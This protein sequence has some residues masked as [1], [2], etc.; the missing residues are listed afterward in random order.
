MKRKKYYTKGKFELQI[1]YKANPIEV[2]RSIR[3]EKTKKKKFGLNLLIMV[4]KE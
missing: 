3:P 4:I 2:L 1:P